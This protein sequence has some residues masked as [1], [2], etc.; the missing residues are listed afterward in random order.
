MKKPL[1]LAAFLL[2]ACGPPVMK[3]NADLRLRDLVLSKSA[4]PESIAPLL[5]SDATVH[6]AT[7]T[8][9][10]AQAAAKALAEVKPEGQTR[11]YRHHDVSL[12]VLGDGRV[13]LIQRGEEDHVTR[14]VELRSPAP[15]D[16]YPI[17]AIYY[18]RAWN[19]DDARSRNALL[20]AMWA[21]KG[22][23]VDP[24]QDVT[25]PES[26]SKMIGNFRFIFPGSKV[27]STSGVVEGGDGWVTF[28]WV[29]ISRLGRRELY[30]GFDVAHIDADGK[31]EFLAGFFGTRYPE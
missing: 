2:V 17:Q 21:E 16:G 10:G 29:I 15:G 4:T 3:G 23:Y 8:V 11:I 14:A 24:M 19:A 7:G 9:Q 22:R 13:L 12:L 26:V 25:G 18:D 5:A 28:D 1:V 20:N 6:R 31:I 27:K 30:K